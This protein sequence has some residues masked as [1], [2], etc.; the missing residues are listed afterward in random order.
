ML[1]NYDDV[2]HLYNEL[3]NKIHDLVDKELADCDDEKE[4]EIRQKL[5]ETFRFW[6]R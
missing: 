5:T 2:Q 1:K 6:K 4:E 3:W